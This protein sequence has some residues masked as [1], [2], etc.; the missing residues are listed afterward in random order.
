M[1]NAAKT[2]DFS[3]HVRLDPP[4]HFFLVPVFL[5]TFL[6][7]I[8]RT[9]RHPSFWN[10]WLILVALAAVVALGLMRMYSLRVQDRVIR[11]EE[12][13]RLSMLD[14]E[15]LLGSRASDLTMGQVAALRFA[16]DDEVCL[17][18]QRALNEN[19]KPKEIKQSIKN[20]RPDFHRV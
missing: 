6:F 7:Q 12:R 11:L 4:F 17:L 18:A 19:L 8:A 2:Q 9:V 13:L 14:R 20:W 15:G 16:C 5:L 1:A 10:G 3:N